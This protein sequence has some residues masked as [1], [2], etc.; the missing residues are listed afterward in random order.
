MKLSNNIYKLPLVFLILVVAG[1]TEKIDVKL[2]NTYKRLVV[3]AVITSDT[4]VHQVKLSTTTDYFFNEP[5]PPVSNAIVTI[6]DGTETIILKEN[7]QFPGIYET[8]A[9][10]YG[11]A[12]KTY[13]LEIK[14]DNAINGNATYEA[15]SEMHP[16]APLDSIKL[17][18]IPEWDVIAVQTYAQ[19]PLSVDYYMFKTFK[20]GKL[21]SDTL[22]KV[23]ITDDK[24]FNGSYTN[25]IPA[26][27]LDQKNLLE[28][29]KPG[30]TITLQIAGIT[31]DYFNFISDVQS[32]TG[33]NNPLFGGPPANI[34]GNINKG[35]I[36]FFAAYSVHY[37]STLAH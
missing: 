17:K 23:F 26:S 32:G 37:A 1:C 34:R 29:V 7:S 3:D 10:F 12:G 35:A 31:R 4:T 33:F 30:D 24:L 28:K 5:A 15:I 21:L 36:G 14:L 19:D 27:Y 6:S 9:N 13:K 16:V 20:N 11:L 8:P 22:N 2:D 18:L 25:G